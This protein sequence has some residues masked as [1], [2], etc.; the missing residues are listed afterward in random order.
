MSY[1]FKG[2]CK[3]DV[4]ATTTP[5]L[6]SLPDGD[7]GYHCSVRNTGDDVLLV[8]PNTAIADFDILTAVAID[9]DEV[10][11]FSSDQ[12]HIEGRKL[13]SICYSSDSTTTMKVTFS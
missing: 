10:F 4:A 12:D 7:Y 9:P 13:S 3:R 6:L 11:S 5:A 2:Y 8:S 1:Q